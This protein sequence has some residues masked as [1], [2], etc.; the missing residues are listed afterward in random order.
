M[1]ASASISTPASWK[2]I[3]PTVDETVADQLKGLLVRP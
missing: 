3:G 1:I 2:M